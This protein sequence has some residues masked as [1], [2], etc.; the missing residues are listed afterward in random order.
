MDID[1]NK[2]KLERRDGEFVDRKDSNEISGI[3]DI[4]PLLS[5][6]ESDEPW[7]FVLERYITTEEPYVG[8]IV[9]Q[10][11]YNAVANRDQKLFGNIN[12]NDWDSY[13]KNLMETNE[14]FT[15]KISNFW[16]RTEG[17]SG[18]IVTGKQIGRAHV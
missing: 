12:F 11:I 5:K 3:F 18:S 16:G 17:T 6:F 4:L 15:G 1:L 14:N 9:D 2:L 10:T 13:I 8:K 7:P